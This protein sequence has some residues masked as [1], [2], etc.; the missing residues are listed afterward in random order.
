MP[1][2]R[3]DDELCLGYG[4]CVEIAPELFEIDQDGIA[5]VLNPHPPANLLDKARKAARDC[6]SRAIILEG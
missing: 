2:L 3:V 1:T 4:N 5:H 6:P